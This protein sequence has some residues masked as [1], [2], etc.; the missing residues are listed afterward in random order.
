MDV[1]ES[2]KVKVEYEA[3]LPIDEECDPHDFDDCES[4]EEV[5]ERVCNFTLLCSKRTRS[6]AGCGGGAMSVGCKEN[7]RGYSAGQPKQ[8][9]GPEFGI[10]AP[11]CCTATAARWPQPW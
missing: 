8:S 4:E 1:S 7:W 3:P 9:I 2:V 5:Y 10:Q 6:C 11:R